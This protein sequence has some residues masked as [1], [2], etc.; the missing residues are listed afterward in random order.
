MKKRYYLYKLT[1]LLTI[2]VFTGACADEIKESSIEY[3]NDV[4]FDELE[5]TPF[6]HKTPDA[7]FTSA[8]YH[9]GVITFN[10][11]KNADGSHSGF[12]LS[13][14]NYRSYP[15]S[16]SIPHGYANPDDAQIKEAVDSCIYSVFSGTYPNQLGA[17]AVVRVEGDEAC[18]TL[19]RPRTV[20]HVLVANTTCN[21]L[22]LTYGSRYSSSLDATT[23]AYLPGQPESP[24]LVRNPNIPDASS[25]KFGV[26]HLPTSH[27]DLI[28]LEGQQILHKRQKGH[29][30]AEAA[31]ADG[32][33][34][35]VAK[36]DSTTA[37]TNA[38]DGYFKLIVK[39]FNA[40]TPTGSVEY[41]LATLAKVAPA[42][43]SEW[44]IIQG[45][46]AKVDL[47]ALGEVD[48]V[49]FYLDS[50]DKDANGNMRTP[51]YFCLDGIRL[52]K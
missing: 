52:S 29:E 46:W 10:A 37:A 3:P 8:A 18:F 49:I 33:P 15:W 14:R 26:W 50:S 45:F 36:S 5:L 35:S 31:R 28:R 17:F 27:G 47:S 1:L 40:G 4:V 43:Y 22:L 25:S 7:A 23:Q 41:Y 30:A 34:E 13:S 32:K 11:K 39:G 20:E 9:S 51:P 21:Y 2:L 44:N 16:L 24:A 38:V 6:T 42:P 48:K 19:D 12:A